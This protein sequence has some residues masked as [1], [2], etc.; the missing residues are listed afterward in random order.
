MILYFDCETTGLPAKDQKWDEHYKDFPHIV[1]LAWKTGKKVNHHIV[2][3]DGYKI[4]KEATAIHG[5]TTQHALAQGRP[6]Q[7]V[8][9]EF[10]EDAIVAEKVVAHN[11][12]FDSSIIKA[13]TLRTFGTDSMQAALVCEGLHKDK[14]LDTMKIGHRLMKGKWPSLVELHK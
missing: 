7:E 1:S 13:N 9:C 8:V 5:I 10:L 2:K 3:P 12:Y 6:V 4:P 11:T 14:R